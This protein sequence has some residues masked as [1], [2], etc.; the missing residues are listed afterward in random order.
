M[1]ATSRFFIWW[2]TAWNIGG[3]VV[4]FLLAVAAIAWLVYDSRTRRIPATGW[5]MGAVLAALLLIPSAIFGFSPKTMMEMANLQ[6]TF[7]YLGLIGGIVPIVVAVGYFITYQGMR[8]CPQ[9]HIYSASLGECPE[10][11]AARPAAEAYQPPPAYHEP[12]RRREYEE[13]TEMPSRRAA[14]P[15]KRKANAWLLEERTNRNH[16]LNQGDTRVGRGADND[17]VLRDKA[18]SREHMLIREERGHFTLYDRGSR[19]GTYVNGTRMEGPLL[20]AHDDV[21]D[22]GDTRLRFMTTRG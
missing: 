10:C 1:D 13:P 17:I 6:E 7:F 12:I 3:W 18:V 19:S 8:G 15:S 2:F 20:L 21:I 4:F 16:Q 11:Q 14:R 9:G 22:I 5:L